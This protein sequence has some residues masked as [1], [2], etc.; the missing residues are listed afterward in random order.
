MPVIDIKLTTLEALKP[1]T[2]RSFTKSCPTVSLN[3]LTYDLDS[4]ILGRKIFARNIYFRPDH[5]LRAMR[6][7]F[8]FDPIIYYELCP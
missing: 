8:T 5:L 7:I 6:V 4:R 2:T 3:P 1:L